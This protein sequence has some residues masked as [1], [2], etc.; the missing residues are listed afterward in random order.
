MSKYKLNPCSKCGGKGRLYDFEHKYSPSSRSVKFLISAHDFS[1]AAECINCGRYTE[2]FNTPIDA[3]N[4][5]N[6][7]EIYN[8]KEYGEKKAKEYTGEIY[9]EEEI[10][11]FIAELEWEEGYVVDLWLNNEDCVRIGFDNGGYFVFGLIVFEKD[12][13]KMLEAVFN[14]LNK[15]SL[16][17]KEITC[18]L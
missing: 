18:K 1:T 15:S 5:W 11:K 10:R 2:H 3:I 7:G 6:K 8:F 9:T 12:I 17:V 14:Y 13:N 16:K 4:C